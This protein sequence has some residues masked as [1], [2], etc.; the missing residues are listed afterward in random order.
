M[1]C[2]K[3]SGACVAMLLLLAG[4]PGGGGVDGDDGSTT[5]TPDDSTTGPANTTIPLPPLDDSTTSGSSSGSGTSGST[6][7]TSTDPGTTT[8][9]GPIDG[10]SSSSSGEPAESSSSDGGPAT[11]SVDW[12]ILQYPPSVEVGVGEPFTIYVRLYA[13]GLTDDTGVTDPA[14]ELV[15]EVGWSVDGSD[16]STGVGEPWTWETAM[17]NDGYGPGSPGYGAVNDEYWHDLAIAEAGVFDYAARIS[18]DSGSTWV[19]CDLDGLT[20]DGYTPD[21]AGNAAVGQ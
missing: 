21:Q 18:G 17:P 13:P 9:T 5:T 6:D 12:C 7:G 16:P 20:E 14:P 2:I 11:Y 10:S 15:V 3:G 4:C 19:Y 1:D 8:T